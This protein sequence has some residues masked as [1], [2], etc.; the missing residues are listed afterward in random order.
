MELK[1]LK[2]KNCGATLE[3]EEGKRVDSESDF[4][5]F[6]PSFGYITIEVK[7]GKNIV[8]EGTHWFLV[9]HE[10]GEETTRELKC[11]PYEQAEKRMRHFYS[12]FHDEFHHSLWFC[13]AL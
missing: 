8:Q 7:G 1:E 12:Y 4:I 3:V 13:I 5:V 2:C 10:N 11:S 9:E 6:D